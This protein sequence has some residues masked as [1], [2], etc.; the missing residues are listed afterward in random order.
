[1]DRIKQLLFWL[2]KYGVGPVLGLSVGFAV[3]FL[4]YPVGEDR[5]AFWAGLAV[6]L[7]AMLTLV[8]VLWLGPAQARLHARLARTPAADGARPGAAFVGVWTTVALLIVAGLTASTWMLYRQ[9]QAFAD[10]ARQQQQQ[11]Q[12]QTE[13]IA[14]IKNGQQVF[15]MSHVLD[16]VQS[17][18]SASP[19]RDLSA[20]TIARVAALSH[21][22]K[23]Y[24]IVSGDSLSTQKWSPER[25]Q[26]LLALTAMGIDSAAFA[27][28]KR[29]TTFAGAELSGAKLAGADLSGADLS[30]ANLRD[31]DLRGADLRHATLRHASLWGA[32][33]DSARLQGAELLRADLRWAELPAATLDSA[34]LNGADLR[35]A[36]FAQAHMRGAKIRYAQGEGVIFQ[37]ADLQG[38]D[39]MSSMLAKADLRQADLRAGNMR[40]VNLR[41][42]YL[43]GI[44]WAQTRVGKADWT[45]VITEWQR[46]D[47]GDLTQRFTVVS[48]TTKPLRFE[49]LFMLEPITPG[50]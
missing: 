17:E 48:D 37:A 19:A 15:L 10:Q 38:A 24:R 2:L 44:T 20:A 47:V 40:E 14:S 41:D 13:L 23:P 32:R 29:A 27:R 28:L 12:A 8:V 45:Q 1:M 11:L 35:N 46:T 18:L 34:V 3:G 21:S 31:A 7:A 42:A 39:F 30:A 6:G 22:L 36:T 5:H 49:A 26:L 9:N 50:Q 43:D 25:G 33:L 4:R 16:Q